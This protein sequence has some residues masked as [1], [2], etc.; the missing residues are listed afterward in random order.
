MLP[1]VSC[2]QDMSC[3]QGSV[4]HP[5]KARTCCWRRANTTSYLW[6]GD[7]ACG[8]SYAQDRRAEDSDFHSGQLSDWPRSTS[9]VCWW[10]V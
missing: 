9:C 8:H 3:M 5:G 4:M 2:M 7:H 1:V 6:R 10:T